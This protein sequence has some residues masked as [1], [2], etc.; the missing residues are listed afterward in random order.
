MRVLS[1]LFRRRF[2]EELENLYRDGPLKFFGDHVDLADAETFADWLMPLRQCEWVVNAKRPF[3]GPEAVPAY[4][5]RWRDVTALICNE[6]MAP[7]TIEVATL[8]TPI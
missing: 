1:R 8:F 2:L 3:A 5:S 4:L 7:N 6:T